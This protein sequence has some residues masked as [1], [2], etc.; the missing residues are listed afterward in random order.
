[1]LMQN[2]NFE[3]ISLVIYELVRK[4][5]NAAPIQ[6]TNLPLGTGCLNFTTHHHPSRHQAN[7]R[8]GPIGRRSISKKIR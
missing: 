1:M 6:I 7:Y 2:R 4:H 8:V 5:Q 3:S